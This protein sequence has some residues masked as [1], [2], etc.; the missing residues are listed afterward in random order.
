[1]E[2]LYRFTESVLPRLGYEPYLTPT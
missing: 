1:M 2:Q